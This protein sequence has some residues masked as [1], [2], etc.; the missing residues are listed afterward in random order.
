MISIPFASFNC[1][2][3]PKTDGGS[4][5]AVTAR[6]PLRGTRRLGCSH[7][8]LAMGHARQ[9]R[10]VGVH[11]YDGCWLVVEPYPSEKYESQLG[12]LFPTEWKNKKCSKAPTINIHLSYGCIVFLVWLVDPDIDQLYQEKKS[13]WWWPKQLL[14]RPGENMAFSDL[15]LPIFMSD[16]LSISFS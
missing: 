15:T 14:Q 2:K 3:P 16:N 8:D 7:L 6:P 13:I 9:A 1:T 11:T 4:Q 5:E 12:W 10:H